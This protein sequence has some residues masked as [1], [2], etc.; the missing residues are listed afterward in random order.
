MNSILRFYLFVLIILL[1]L[2]SIAQ[3]QKVHKGLNYKKFRISNR[4]KYAEKFSVFGSTG[5]ANYYGDLCD[6]AKCIQLRPH[7]GVGG[8]YR[9]ADNITSK[10]EINYIRLYS[11]GTV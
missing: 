6:N 5:L 11:K 9:L 3:H 8:M 1:P 10:S 4:F 2:S 7:I